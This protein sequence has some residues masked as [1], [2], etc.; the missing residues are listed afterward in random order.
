[1]SG[2]KKPGAEEAKAF[3]RIKQLLGAEDEQLVRQGAEL[4]ISLDVP[5]M[6][7]E[8]AQ[9]VSVDADGRLVEP[10]GLA[11]RLLV[12]SAGPEIGGCGRDAAVDG[13]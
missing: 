10:V 1:M 7:E 6:A 4:L 13:E 5:A 3:Q 11:V 2:V 12:P 8:L 9:G